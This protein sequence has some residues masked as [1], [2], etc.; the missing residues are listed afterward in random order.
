MTNKIKVFENKNIRTVWN[1]EEEDWYFSVVDVCYILSESEG[2]D[3]GAYWRKLKQRLKAEGS[4]VVTKCH[5][6]KLESVDGKSYKTDC[7]STKNILRLIQSIPSPKAEPFKVW[8][9]QVGSERLDE[10]AD[11]EKAIL[12]GADFYRA[13]GY[14]EKWI[15]Q[16]LQT[17][18]MRKELTD[19]W[20]NR[21]IEQEKDY[22]ILTNEMTKA[23]SGLSVKE[24][25]NL[26]GLKKENLRDNMTNLELVLNM[27]AEVT[28]TAISKS[29]EPETFNES[30]TIAKEGGSVAK[31]AR[32]D[33]ENRIGKNV[34][35]PLN[36]KDK[37][38]LEVK[39]EE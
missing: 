28:T 25:K 29:K 6:L 30:L 35:S 20:K 5:A 17:I 12:R 39:E 34:I 24:Y 32:T 33:I 11:P 19:E 1:E 38:A 10:I 37:P 15:N 36:A 9:A 23:W 8:L 7:L 13:K 21:G 2:K 22:A 31:N 4:E 16:R 14:T 26:K 3:I 18:E 27:L